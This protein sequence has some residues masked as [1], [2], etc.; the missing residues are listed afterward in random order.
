MTR[1]INAQD[2]LQAPTAITAA[3]FAMVLDGSRKIDTPEGKAEAIIGRIGDIVDGY[4]ARK[5]D[6]TSDAGAIADVTADK[7]GM[8]AIAIGAW[9]HDIVPKPILAAMAAKHV[10]NAAAT[11]YN[12]LTDEK[13]R[14]IRPPKSGKYSMAA[15]TVSLGAFML[16][17]E[18]EPH[19]PGYRIARRIGYTAFAAGMAFG[20]VSTRHYV[21][22]EFDD[23][24]T[25]H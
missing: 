11:L 2:L 7:L 5:F 24:D 12:G 4:V 17:D 15:D 9:R 10:T 8:L 18:L 25:L 14:S 1:Q 22:G 19:S 21:K 13:K 3:S 23:A 20:T 6:M 16:A